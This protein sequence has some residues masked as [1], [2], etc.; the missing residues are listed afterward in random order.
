MKWGRILGSPGREYKVLILREINLI[1]VRPFEETTPTAIFT[2]DVVKMAAEGCSK[3]LHVLGQ[4]LGYRLDG[5]RFESRR[6]RDILLFPI[7]SRSPL[8]PTQPPTEW[9]PRVKRPDLDVE[10]APQSSA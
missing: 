6:R 7:S 9:V 2:V 8:G 4:R 10:H 1:H 5:S 3:I